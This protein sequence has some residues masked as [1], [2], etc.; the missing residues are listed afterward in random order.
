MKKV[1]KAYRLNPGT[2]EQIQAIREHF[3]SEGFH[4]SDANII[5][6][7]VSAYMDTVAT[8]YKMKKT[9]KEGEVK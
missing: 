6:K 3:A 9:I 4:Y 1:Q 5:E 7:A 8:V 2:I